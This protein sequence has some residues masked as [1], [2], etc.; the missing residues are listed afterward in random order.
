MAYITKDEK[1]RKEVEN[2]RLAASIFA[3][4][5]GTKCVKF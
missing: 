5:A 2:L 4:L 3:W 1:H